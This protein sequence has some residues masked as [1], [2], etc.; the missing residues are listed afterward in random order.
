M[1]KREVSKFQPHFFLLFFFSRSSVRRFSQQR[2]YKQTNWRPAA[3][4]KKWQP[5][6]I[7]SPR[8]AAVAHNQIV[9]HSPAKRPNSLKSNN[10]PSTL[11][12]PRT[13]AATRRGSSEDVST[14]S[15]TPSPPLAVSKDADKGHTARLRRV[16]SMP[17]NATSGNFE[18]LL[19]F[20][21]CTHFFS[22]P[23]AFFFSMCQCVDSVRLAFTNH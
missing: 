2:Q 17:D 8:P 20:Q 19:S 7:G 5:S 14:E 6:Y 21:L 3:S 10:Q 1:I 12:S 13:R 11:T 18:I 23:V 4:G 22:L 15:K 9:N 16:F